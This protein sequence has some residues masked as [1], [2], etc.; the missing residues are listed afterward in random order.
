VSVY[1]NVSKE[2]IES[3]KDKRFPVEKISKYNATVVNIPSADG[4]RE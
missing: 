3:G 1:L 4:N 2:K